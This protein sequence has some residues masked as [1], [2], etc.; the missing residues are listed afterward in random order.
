MLELQDTANW[1]GYVKTK[2]NE[3]EFG[4]NKTSIVLFSML[5]T[6]LSFISLTDI[7]SKYIALKFTRKRTYNSQYAVSII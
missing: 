5:Y 7:Y 3:D 1:H 6:N 4:T 2:V